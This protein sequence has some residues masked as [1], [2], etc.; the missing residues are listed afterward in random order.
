MKKTIELLR[1]LNFCDVRPANS[2][3]PA[4][5]AP[6]IGSPPTEI[7]T[8]DNGV[9]YPRGKRLEV[10]RDEEWEAAEPHKGETWFK[11]AEHPGGFRCTKRR[12]SL[13]RPG[14]RLRGSTGN[15]KCTF[16]RF[17]PAKINAASI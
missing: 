15:Q 17:L 7:T 12:L 8:L 1:D 4:P 10:E 14:K 11:S 16:T 3:Q 9:H 6:P 5:P 2:V 13:Y